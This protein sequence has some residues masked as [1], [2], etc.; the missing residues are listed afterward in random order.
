MFVEETSQFSKLIQIGIALSSIHHL[1]KLLDLIVEKAREFTNSDG[2]SLYIREGDGLKFVVSQNDTLQRRSGKK[3]LKKSFLGTLLP[4][5]KTSLAGYVAVKGKPLNLP[6]AYHIPEELPMQL[7]REFDEKNNY[8]TKS[9]LMIPMKDQNDEVIGVLQ[10]INAQNGKGEVVS[11]DKRYESL[12]ESL[13]SQAAV[14]VTNAKLTEDIKKAHLDTIWRLSV[15]AEYRD[16]DT[17]SH[18]RRISNYSF[19]LAEELGQPPDWCELLFYA[20]PMHDIGKIGVPDSIL[21]KPDVLSDEERKVMMEHTE[22]GANILAGSDELLLKMSGK[23]A[24]THHEK[25]DGTGYPRNLISTEIPLSGRIV[26]LADVFDALISKRCYKTAFP[27]NKVN[28][29]ITEERGKHFDPDIVDAFF[30]SYDGFIAVQKKYL[31]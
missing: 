20:S 5:D 10:L 8:R 24:L 4:L 21:L 25:W 6:D 16:E 13:A 31:E 12:V 29:I 19:I 27:L 3:L 1:D 26:A 18:I 14:A 28:G 30:S 7:N 9:L 15:A 23:I 11:F 17:A 2:G 22:I